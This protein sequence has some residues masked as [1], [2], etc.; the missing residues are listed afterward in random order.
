[1]PSRRSSSRS[2]S[3][4]WI[5]VPA[6]F[7]FAF[8]G[9][10][11]TQEPHTASSP[12]PF[13]F[14][15]VDLELLE[16]SNELDRQIAHR[17]LIY[18]DSGLT[19]YLTAVGGDVLPPGPDPVNV[20]WQFH[21]L[22]DP[23]PNAFALPNGSIYVHSG[24]LALLENEA[25]LASVLAHEESHV[26]YRHPYLGNRS[27][28]KKALAENILSG[29]A[30]A[31][32]AAGGIGGAAGAL[33]GTLAP[34]IL[35]S[36]IYGYSRELEKQAD[37][38][39]VG[40][41]NDAN[42]STEE[43]VIVFKLLDSPHEVDLSSHFYQDHP[44]LTDRI[45]Y[46]SDAIEGMHAPTA[47]PL[48][49]DEQYMAAVE[50]VSRDNIALDIS[51]G[52]QR[53]AVATAQRLVKIFPKSAE[54]YRVLGDAFR[55]LGARTPDPTP[56]ERTSHGKGEERKALVKLTPQEYE[57]KLMASDAGKAA[58]DFNRKQSEDAYR[59]ALEIDPAD[60]AAHRGLGFLYE[61]EQLP[62]QGAAEF[63]KYLE[64]APN[65]FDQAQVHRHIESDNKQ[66]DS[67]AAPPAKP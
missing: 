41:I 24:L 10:A 7:L 37:L 33:L 62:A 12:P 27:Y 65:A 18:D 42:Y 54:N 64:L 51:A 8:A 30:V 38:H 66:A 59:K 35:D 28:R 60:A 21:V 6:A 52:R 39:A 34:A 61:R 9:I 4:P 49:K 25:Q 11:S 45:G 5:V 50:Q 14:T 44:K 58:W 67:A 53:T 31:G 55:A 29:V 46:V 13:T 2:D 26:I 23:I 48:V 32:G 1:M 57:S 15:Q 17:G 56:E 63:Q 16:K 3:L 19:D 36:S 40:A 22:R 20:K 47:H 43:M